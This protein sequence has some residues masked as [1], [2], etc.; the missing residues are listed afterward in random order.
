M[1]YFRDRIRSPR[2]R[3]LLRNIIASFVLYIGKYILQFIQ[4]LWLWKYLGP[5]YYGLLSFGTTIILYF[6]IV[7]EYGFNIPATRQVSMNRNNKAF[8]IEI[9]G[10]V[11][12]MKLVFVFVCAGV[13]FP[14]IVLRLFPYGEFW[15][16]YIIFFGILF[17]YATTSNFIF[18]GMER[19][20]YITYNYLV[21][22]FIYMI[23][24]ILFVHNFTDYWIA[25]VFEM[26]Y[27]VLIGILNVIVIKRAF[28]IGFKLPS[29]RAIRTQ[30][31]EG[32]W[33]FIQIMI[34]SIYS[35]SPVLFL[36]L[37]VSNLSNGL[38]IVG[39]YSLAT[40]IIAAAQGL[41]STITTVVFPRVT[42]LVQDSQDQALRFVKKF[43]IL[44]LGL[45][46]AIFLG[47]FFL[48]GFLPLGLALVGIHKDLTQI[49]AILKIQSILPVILVINNTLGMQIMLAL[50]YKRAFTAV[51]AG[52]FSLCL[53]LTIIFVPLF[54][55]IAM[56]AII[57]I[58]ETFIMTVEYVYLRR[59]GINIF[60]GIQ[61][62]LMNIFKNRKDEV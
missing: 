16:V 47:I 4:Y 32:A 60:E 23:C 7:V 29:V 59:R 18:Q 44:L 48:S 11:V 1:A 54:Y 26:S 62:N 56:A 31:R 45:G 41:I 15:Q 37:F 49:I 21:S 14:M 42:K 34:F 55:E 36:G 33:M 40:T 57:V 8:L 2:Y 52:A 13:Y 22:Y 20:K 61:N 17:G 19:F 5:Y 6:D 43:F 28:G 51:Y 30:L 27:M 24:L 50:N 39:Y 46:I 38:A 53:V 12:F 25:A 35:Y 58:V 10:T 3:Q 9:Y